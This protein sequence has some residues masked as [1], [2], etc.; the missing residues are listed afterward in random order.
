MP[1]KHWNSYFCSVQTTELTRVFP[2]LHKQDPIPL[3]FLEAPFNLLSILFYLEA[4]SE[5]NSIVI[6]FILFFGLL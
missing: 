4:T 5:S 6:S 2:A 1:C 3:R